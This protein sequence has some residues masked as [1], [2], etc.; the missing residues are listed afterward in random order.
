MEIGSPLEHDSAI[1]EGS[2]SRAEMAEALFHTHPARHTPET[3]S[4]RE[5][6]VLGVCGR[7]KKE[8]SCERKNTPASRPSTRLR[9][10]TCASPIVHGALYVEDVVK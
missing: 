10:A 3:K 4:A 7:L 6:R 8:A 9:C 2:S 5:R 1:R